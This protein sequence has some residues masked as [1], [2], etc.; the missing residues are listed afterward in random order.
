VAAPM[1]NRWAIHSNVIVVSWRRRMAIHSG[2]MVISWRRRVALLVVATNCLATVAAVH[3]MVNWPVILNSEFPRHPALSL[4]RRFRRS[5]T[6]RPR[7]ENQQS[8]T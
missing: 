2:V 7:L 8:L 5:S 6:K 1:F 3:Y 4:E